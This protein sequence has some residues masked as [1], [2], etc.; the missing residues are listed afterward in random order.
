[1]TFSPIDGKQLLVKTVEESGLIS[2]YNAN[3]ETSPE[4]KIYTN[5][6]VI[7]INNVTDD[8]EK[9]LEQCEAVGRIVLKVVHGEDYKAAPVP[10]KPAAALEEPALEPA[11]ANEAPKD[12]NEIQAT[13]A[14]AAYEAPKDENSAPVLLETGESKTDDSKACCCYTS[15]V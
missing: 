9:M 14:P 6:I 7:D 4:L 11:A 12:E 13:E 5:D 2:T 15:G 8:S 10:A 3:N 1:L